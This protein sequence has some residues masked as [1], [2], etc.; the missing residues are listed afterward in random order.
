MFEVPRHYQWQEIFFVFKIDSTKQP[1]FEFKSS[2]TTFFMSF[3]E[4][5]LRFFSPAVK[6]ASFDHTNIKSK[7]WMIFYETFFKTNSNL[8]RYMMVEPE[9]NDTD[10]CS[11]KVLLCKKDQEHSI[12]FLFG[13]NRFHLLYQLSSRDDPN[14]IE[15]VD[16]CHSGS[17][18]Y[19]D[20]KTNS[21]DCLSRATGKKVLFNENI[22]NEHSFSLSQARKRLIPSMSCDSA[23]PTFI[24]Y[25]DGLLGFALVHELLQDE[26]KGGKEQEYYQTFRVHHAR[27]LEHL[28]VFQLNAVDVTPQMMAQ[29]RTQQV[30]DWVATF[31][32]E[33]M[34][35]G[36]S[37]F[38]IKAL[39][40]FKIWGSSSTGLVN[41]MEHVHVRVIPCCFQSW[42]MFV[43]R[44]VNQYLD[45]I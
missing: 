1:F 5:W 45:R 44:V 7:F 4:K 31:Q 42:L 2:Q 36:H 18:Q 28:P 13:L 3:G 25:E 21:T 23:G 12:H 6:V 17:F 40:D 9:M 15:N 8:G 41:T 26:R 22:M 19:F 38:Q 33:R 11:R 34:D 30:L 35:R 24:Q 29:L 32:M 16:C 10:V 39:G 14:R 43:I 20:F 37:E 27:E